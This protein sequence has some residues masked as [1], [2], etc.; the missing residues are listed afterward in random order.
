M[1]HIVNTTTYW[2]QNPLAFLGAISMARK[3]RQYVMAI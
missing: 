2:N 3:M 1:K